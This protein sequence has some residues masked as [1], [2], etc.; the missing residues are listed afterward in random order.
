M[1]SVS[2]TD[3][4]QTQTDVFKKPV[5]TPVSIPLSQEKIERMRAGETPVTPQLS[6]DA[7]DKSQKALLQ[8]RNTNIELNTSKANAIVNDIDTYF[9]GMLSHSSLS[10]LD[11]GGLISEALQTPD[12]SGNSTT[13]SMDLSLTQAKLNLL[14]QK[15][16]P[17]EHQAASVAE[18]NHYLAKKTDDQDDIV[19]DMTSRSLAIAKQYGDTAGEK[20]LSEQLLQLNAG[21]HETQNER[22]D[23]LSLTNSTTDS[24]AWFSGLR[25]GIGT[26]ND[27][28]F[29]KDIASGHVAKLQQQWA[30]FMQSVN[31]IAV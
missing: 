5:N 28:D 8:A 11:M 14:V 23:M 30:T 13:L 4:S 27:A 18:I 26:R 20:S 19:K 9:S 6:Q 10:S 12:G 16:V 24:S 29:F 15:F 3:L 2:V 1:S 21:Q 25:Q 7:I 17:T 22:R 31:A